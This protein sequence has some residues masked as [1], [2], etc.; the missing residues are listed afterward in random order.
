VETPTSAGKLVRMT[1]PVRDAVTSKAVGSEGISIPSNRS[2]RDRRAD[3]SFRKRP[4][5]VHSIRESRPSSGE[6][7]ARKEVHWTIWSASRLP[8]W[9]RWALVGAF[10]L[11]LAWISLLYRKNRPAASRVVTQGAITVSQ[12]FSAS[13]SVNSA[14]ALSNVPT[15]K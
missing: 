10:A 11:T 2:I 9:G 5:N 6:E 14:S 8:A 13:T 15:E 4:S 7:G 1:V 12:P 3:W